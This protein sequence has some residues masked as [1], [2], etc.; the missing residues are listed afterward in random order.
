M[1]GKRNGMGK[2]IMPDGSVFI[3]TFYNNV[4]NGKGKLY[5]NT[6]CN[7]FEGEWIDGKVLEKGTLVW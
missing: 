5:N 6:E 1:N 4:R 2:E 7:V 3:G